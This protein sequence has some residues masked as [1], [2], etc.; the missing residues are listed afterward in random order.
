MQEHIQAFQK[1]ERVPKKAP[2]VDCSQHHTDA[3]PEFLNDRVLRDYQIISLH[4]MM[5][6]FR[7]NRSC[8]LGDEMVRLIL[9]LFQTVLYQAK[10]G[11][12]PIYACVC[13]FSTAWLSQGMIG[14]RPAFPFKAVS[15]ALQYC[16]EYPMDTFSHNMRHIILLQGLGKTAQ[17]IATLAFQKQFLGV[18]GPHIVIAPLTTLGHWQREIQTWTDMVRCILLFSCIARQGLQKRRY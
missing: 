14:L 8:I 11:E 4:W 13:S 5:D 6:N 15:T 2:P 1:R 10:D 7:N 12:L 17:S 18:T 3:V 9:L 16:G